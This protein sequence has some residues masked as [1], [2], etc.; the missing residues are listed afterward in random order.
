MKAIAMMQPGTP[1][2]LELMDVPQPTLT[3]D[4]QLLIRLRAAGVNPVDTKIRKRGPLIDDPA[5]TILGCDGAGVVEEVGDR[6]TAFKPGDEVYY[7]FGGL[8]KTGTGNY[9]Q[10][11][12]V[13]DHY[14]AP[15]PQNLSFAEAAAAP[16]VLITA[17]EALYDRGRLSE[18]QT[19]L[20]H[21]GAGGVGH[22]AIQLAKLRG[23]QVITT[24]GNP[25][26]ARLARQLGADE[27]ILYKQVNFAE[28]ALKWTD[29]QGVDLAFDTVG[30]QTFFDSFAAVRI[31]GDIVTL[32]EPDYSLG[33]L[34]VARKRNQ[35]ISLELMLT[36]MLAGL[37]DAQKYHGDILRQC[38]TWFEQGK[39]TL[40]LS[41][42]YPLAEAVA[43]HT[44]IEQG[45]MTGKVALLP[46]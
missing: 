39:L 22:V 13:E 32:L 2:V 20:I 37:Q 17:W 45:S 33:N 35:R 23:A 42:T 10:Y 44:A 25:D 36:P 26:K 3:Q 9:T 8:G 21:A 7:C 16:L 34:K 19:A 40:H 5:P 14:V 12:V 29:G 18:G 41:Q 6:V 38:S 1:E 28:T 31:Y 4:N 24:V 30:G 43:A 11:A 27:T 46:E 15:K